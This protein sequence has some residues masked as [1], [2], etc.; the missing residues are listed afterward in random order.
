MKKKWTGERWEPDVQNETAL[1]HLHRYAMAMELT[2]G[3]DVLD[4]ACGEGYGSQL[5]ATNARTV[6]GVDN[7]KAIITTAS[8]KY[9]ASPL[10]FI[11]GEATRIPL[12][13]QS[14]DVVV[15]F[16]TLEHLAD[17]EAF[18]VELKRVIRPDGLLIISTPDKDQ[19]TLKSGNTNPFHVNELNRPEFEV[20]LSKY[21]KQVKI[22]TQ[23]TC[24][25]SVISG[26]GITQYDRYSGNHERIIKNAATEALYLVALVSD[27]DLPAI[28]GSL[29]NGQS[30]LEQAL[31]AEKALLRNTLTYRLGHVL[32]SPFKWVKKLFT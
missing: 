32:L 29:F 16:E 17:H 7:D 12:P 19:Y 8:Q 14:V 10:R 18:I 9:K 24:H 20:L 11:T 31:A 13:D 2:A 5:L 22:F 30:V 15:S 28:T 25:S 26:P 23:E 1:E 21:F 4:I 27:N 3:K 6:T